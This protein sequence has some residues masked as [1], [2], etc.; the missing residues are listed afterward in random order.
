MEK[1]LARAIY[2]KMN[3]G[4]KYNHYQLEG[5]IKEDF[6]KY[7]LNRYNATKCIEAAMQDVVD[8]GYA[9]YEEEYRYVPGWYSGGY[10]GHATSQ[11][12][13]IRYYTRLK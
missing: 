8:A 4:E 2:K 1:T 10:V 12:R 7:R 5:L 6:Q 9:K 11:I 3:V 13:Q